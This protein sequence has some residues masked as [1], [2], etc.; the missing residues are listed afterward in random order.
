MHGNSL[1]V[2]SWHAGKRLEGGRERKGSG[3][4]M[5]IIVLL[6]RR[7]MSAFD[8]CRSS[9]GSGRKP[10]PRSRNQPAQRLETCC[11]TPSTFFCCRDASQETESS[12][13]Q[14]SLES[15]CFVKPR[16]NPAKPWESFSGARVQALLIFSA[17]DDLAACAYVH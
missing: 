17:A 1:S 3:R 14:S 15:D 5:H 7:A 13:L 10:T 4:A 2:C 16:S 8:N 9:A 11:Q 12:L 6:D